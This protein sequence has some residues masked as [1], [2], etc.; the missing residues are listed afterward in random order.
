MTPAQVLDHALARGVRLFPGHG[1]GLVWR[2]RGPLPA[3]LRALLAA[4]KREILECLALRR[5]TAHALLDRT[6]A[7][8]LAMLAPA[9]RSDPRLLACA[10]RVVEALEALDLDGIRAACDDAVGLA[11]LLV[12]EGAGLGTPA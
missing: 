12:R 7:V 11:G 3:D 1:G 2:S 5:R 4:N 8:L 10:D 9:Q 6:D